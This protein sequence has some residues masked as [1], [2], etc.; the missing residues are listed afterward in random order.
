M[1]SILCVRHTKKVKV[2]IPE[3]FKVG[4]YPPPKK[5]LGRVTLMSL[6]RGLYDFALLIKKG[7]SMFNV[8]PRT[9]Y[10]CRI[11]NSPKENNEQHFYM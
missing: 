7:V 9:G 11:S 2:R 10:H 8:F 6:P 3:S 4:W 1:L 5:K